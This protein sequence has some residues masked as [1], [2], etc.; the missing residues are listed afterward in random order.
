M[1]VDNDDG[2]GIGIGVGIGIGIDIGIGIG[3][4]GGGGDDDDDDDDEEEEEEEEEE[5]GEEDTKNIEEQSRNMKLVAEAAIVEQPVF[6][7]RDMRVDKNRHAGKHLNYGESPRG[8]HG[9]SEK[10]L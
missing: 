8:T 10:V 4:G 6:Q 9:Y 2:I 5:E 3:I 7:M 1:A